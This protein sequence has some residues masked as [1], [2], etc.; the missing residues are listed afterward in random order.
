MRRGDPRAAR[1]DPKAA[2][3]ELDS[4]RQSDQPS[5]AERRLAQVAQMRALQEQ[6][7]SQKADDAERAA[8]AAAQRDVFVRELEGLPLWTEDGARGRLTAAYRELAKALYDVR[9]QERSKAILAWPTGN[10]SL[11]ACHALSCLALPRTS[12]I[13]FNPDRR[14]APALT[15][16]ALFFPY[17]SRARLPLRRVYAD[18]E[19][20]SA[21][22]ID[23]IADPERRNGPGYAYFSRLCRAKDLDGTVR[24]GGYHFEYEH[25]TLDEVVSVVGL[26]AAKDSDVLGRI[27]HR[28]DL[29]HLSN[30]PGDPSESPYAIFGLPAAGRLKPADRRGE[31][32]DLILLDMTR[33]GRNRLGRD[34]Q[35]D[36]ASAL[37]AT[38][39]AYG[40]L[41]VLAVTDDTYVHSVLAWDILKKHD[42]VSGKAPA[43]YDA[44]LGLTAA[45]VAVED[46]A[47]PSLSAVR[48]FEALSCADPDASLLSDLARGIER[49]RTTGDAEAAGLLDEVAGVVRRTAALPGGI[50]ALGVFVA[51]N[52]GVQAAAQRMAGY[53]L[54][55]LL[56]MGEDLAGPF[57]Q[58]RHSDLVS[59]LARAK[60]WVTARETGSPI[61]L[62]LRSLVQKGLNGSTRK[63]VWSQTS[64]ISE[65]AEHS[66]TTD[67]GI[68][69]RIAQRIASNMITFMDA[70][71][72]REIEALPRV[73]LAGT[74]RMLVVSPRRSQALAL[75]TQPWLP[76]TVTLVADER[77]MLGVG[78]DAG[79]LAEFPAFA[80][81][82]DRLKRLSVAALSEAKRIRGHALDLTFSAP[83]ED[84]D[85]PEGG[86]IDLAGRRA[87]GEK[88]VRIVTEDRRTIL[89][90]RKTRLIT[91]DS[92]G[93]VPT[94][95]SCNAEDVAKGDRLCVI[96]QAFVDMAR[97]RLDI[98]AAAAEEIRDY[99]DR[100]QA[101][102]L[103][104]EG[105]MPTQKLRTLIQRM[106]EPFV[107]EGTA[108]TWTHLAAEVEK[109][110]DLVLPR[111]PQERA[112]FDRF[113]RALSVPAPLAAS[114]WAWAV[115]L[116]RKAR[117][118]A[119]QRLH[120]AYLAILV[121]TFTAEHVS[122]ARRAD[123][124][125][126]RAT[127]EGYVSSVVTT[128]LETVT[129][130]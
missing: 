18:R 12:P 54:D 62:M 106:G 16:R 17:S 81:Y 26:G 84:V 14:R 92:D 110:L 123:I 45:I 63:I 1:G 94:F 19:G 53:S 125:S 48:E 57:A 67:S 85:F 91:Y 75:L 97:A 115:I 116:T 30:R 64:A 41:P 114:Y 39:R 128:A 80:V 100:V 52:E 112:T 46:P 124:R 10:I 105:D 20:V 107:L 118:R 95:S 35:R 33:A 102:F 47:P 23:H 3:R 129:D 83:M 99:H 109:P 61:G 27:A 65:F 5:A 59:L 113:M 24:G 55:R 74:K 56:K 117:I 72:F 119:A 66:L 77:T 127:A 44:I 28:T 37:E 21:V 2:W 90:R 68:G 82:A 120:E 25:P 49:A 58:Q 51:D 43:G 8:G 13:T 69:S 15:L 9:T 50:D 104:L 101:Q 22:S 122:P 130:Q 111:A 31:N 42:G 79:R 71:A 89:A 34:W 87:P 93:P 4:R 78:R 121:D 108:R 32:L 73:E 126:L 60:A 11:A 70:L 76:E 38:T 6:K 40:K 88:V 36:V 7:A 103:L 29:K 96:D 98:R 86:I